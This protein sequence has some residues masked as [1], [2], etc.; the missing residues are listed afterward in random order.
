MRQSRGDKTDHIFRLVFLAWPCHQLFIISWMTIKHETNNYK[1]LNIKTSRMM[2]RLTEL[3]K[4]SHWIWAQELECSASCWYRIRFPPCGPL[5]ST[6]RTV[7]E[8]RGRYRSFY[9]T[10]YTFIYFYLFPV[11][12]F[13]PLSDITVLHLKLCLSLPSF[14]LTPTE[15]AH[16]VNK[17]TASAVF[18][19][20]LR[21]QCGTC[22]CLVPGRCKA[23]SIRSTEC[24]EGDKEGNNPCH[25]VEDSVSESLGRHKQIPQK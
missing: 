13:P 15:Y 16:H 22:V 19:S 6:R 14:F 8:E 12:A 3:K 21:T 17:H 7:W 25:G 1:K 18:L 11:K 2:D 9:C 5:Y 4:N 10:F 23:A 20:P 24:R